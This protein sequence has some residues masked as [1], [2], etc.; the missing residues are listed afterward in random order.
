MNRRPKGPTNKLCQQQQQ[1][2]GHFTQFLL[3]YENRKIWS[4]K[5]KDV[6]EIRNKDQ[7]LKDNQER[8]K[9][10]NNNNNTFLQ[11]T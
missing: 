1:H 2:Q 10:K 3:I 6:H 7:F 8:R 11:S 4:K 5:I 9:T